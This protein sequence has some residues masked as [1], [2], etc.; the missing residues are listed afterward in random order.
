MPASRT[1][2]SG[3]ACGAPVVGLALAFCPR[4][5]G[6]EELVGVFGGWHSF[7]SS[8]AMRA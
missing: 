3:I 4:E 6:T 7:A 5:G 8:S 1:S 2:G